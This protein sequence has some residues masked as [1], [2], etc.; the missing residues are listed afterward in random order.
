MMRS[1]GC[2]GELAGHSLCLDPSLKF[3][4]LSTILPTWWFNLSSLSPTM[5]QLSTDSTY[6]FFPFSVSW[7]DF[8]LSANYSFKSRWMLQLYPIWK[9]VMCDLALVAMLNQPLC[10]RS[11]FSACVFLVD[12]AQSSIISYNAICFVFSFCSLMCFSPSATMEWCQCDI[13]LGKK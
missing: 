6:V 5:C 9:P 13:C 8:K 1:R 2:M 11:H 4:C 12:S 3:M 10:W 7:L